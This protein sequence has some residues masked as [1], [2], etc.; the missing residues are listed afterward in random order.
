MPAAAFSPNEACGRDTHLKIWIGRTVNGDQVLWVTDCIN[1]LVRI[2]RTSDLKEVAQ[3][4]VGKFPHWFTQRPD[5]EVVFVSLW[6]SDAVAAVD[7]KT[8]KVLAN[9]QFPRASGPKRILVAP[10]PPPKPPSPSRAPA[11]HP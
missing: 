5:G 2:V 9:I 11:P 8:R 10:T 7:V 6:Y 1:D 3:V 4:R